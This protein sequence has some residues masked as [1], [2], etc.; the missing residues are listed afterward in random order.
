MNTYK[1]LFITIK[2]NIMKKLNFLIILLITTISVNGQI[3]EEYNYEETSN[4]NYPVYSSYKNNFINIVK[5]EI[6]GEKYV[7][8]NSHSSF[9]A[10]GDLMLD[11]FSV[12]LYNLDH[13]FFKEILVN[14][15]ALKSNPNIPF[16][17]FVKGGYA[18]YISEK[19]FDNDSGVEFMFYY[20]LDSS[21]NYHN[22]IAIIDDN[23][24]SIFNELYK[25]ANEDAIKNTANGT[26]MILRSYDPLTHISATKIYSLPG[27]YSGKTELKHNSFNLSAS[28]NPAQ[29]FTNI[30]YELPE[31]V[32]EGTLT[33]FNMNGNKVKE[34]KVGSQFN[35]I[36]VST[37]ELSTGTYLY[38]VTT[39]KGLSQGRKLIVIQ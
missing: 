35:Y 23:G 3:T 13:S 37:S 32:N 19:L 28:P 29:N 1:K 4:Y 22:A 6:S 8:Y 39:A 25:S 18:G 30:N 24:N 11:S 12:S 34:Y 31:G 38:Q 26:K 14:V 2:S 36:K 7:F 33:I 16:G 20:R 10:N 21:Y 27:I 17:Y 5:L 9:N 15:A